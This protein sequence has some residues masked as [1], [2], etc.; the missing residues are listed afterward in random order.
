MVLA[1]YLDRS[2]VKAAAVPRLPG[3]CWEDKAYD[4]PSL[5]RGPCLPLSSPR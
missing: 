4:A 2:G 3:G 1:G 5:E